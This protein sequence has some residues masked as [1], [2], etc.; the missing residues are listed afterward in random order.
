MHKSQASC[1]QKRK[2]PGALQNNIT[3]PQVKRQKLN[4]RKVEP[5][6]NFGFWDN[7]SKVWLTRGALRELDR[8]NESQAAYQRAQATRRE[9]HQTASSIKEFYS[10]CDACDLKNLNILAKKG[11][12]DLSDIK[13]VRIKAST[14][15]SFIDASEHSTLN[16][17]ISPSSPR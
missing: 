14:L 2:S 13:G 10:N 5:E 6:A 3:K 17:L 8:R 4:H 9:N 11:G 7:L 1:Q 16:H 12:P 15:L